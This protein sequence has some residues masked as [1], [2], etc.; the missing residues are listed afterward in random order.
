MCSWGLL[1][2]EL[3]VLLRGSLRPWTSGQPSWG[4]HAA[5]RKGVLST[6]GPVVLFSIQWSHSS[7]GAL[8]PAAGLEKVEEGRAAFLVTLPPCS[9]GPNLGLKGGFL[10]WSDRLLGYLCPSE[11]CLPDRPQP[12][13]Q[14]PSAG[15]VPDEA[16]VFP[17]TSYPGPLFLRPS[18]QGRP[19][20]S[21]ACLG[22]GVV[23]RA[24]PRPQ[25][26]RTRPHQLPP[27]L[28]ALRAGHACRLP[29]VLSARAGLWAG[30][31]KQAWG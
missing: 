6:E 16:S 21:C 31:T 12:G 22:C 4:G 26:L 28:N 15:P 9:L 27:A 24:A 25:S 2:S 3:S 13:F 8:V 23:L 18:Y 1:L 19:V 7:S 10:S 20:P 29:C 11:S 14:A 5:N 17:A 30:P